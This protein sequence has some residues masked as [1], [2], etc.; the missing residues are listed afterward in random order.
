MTIPGLFLGGYMSKIKVVQYGTWEYC[1]S[2]HIMSTIRSM[3]NLYEIVGVCEPNEQRRK[4][5]MNTECYKELNWL[6]EEEILKNKTLDAVIIETDELE[7][8]SAAL[9]FTK[10]GVNVHLEKPGGATENFE[11]AV[12]NAQKNGTVFHMGYMY[13]YNPAVK[14]SIELVRSGVLGEINYVEAHMSIKYSNDML[15]ML[16]S[17]PSGMM[18]Y[19]GCH[20][21]DLMYKIMGNPKRVIPYN[22]STGSENSSCTDTGFVLYEYKR[23]YSFIKTSAAEV[24]GDARRQLIISGTNGTVEIMPLENPLD[25]PGIICPQDV[26]CKITYKNHIKNVRNFSMRSEIIHF[27]PFGRY[28]EMMKDFY[29]KIKGEKEEEYTYDY[30]LSVHN[31]LMDS[32]KNAN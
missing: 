12:K 20:L 9:K 11:K 23:G 10:Y 17:L 22:F 16:G 27:P 19:L 15:N 31:M 21:T 24:N 26:K 1:H 29:N 4:R 5:A 6:T 7:Q 28:D 25:I 3:P 30:E 14:K 13:R 32:V 18:Y 8:D 2:D